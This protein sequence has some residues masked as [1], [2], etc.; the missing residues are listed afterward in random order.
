MPSAKLA[1]SL[2]VWLLALNFAS[3]RFFIT[4]IL[5]LEQKLRKLGSSEPAKA[6]A[7]K[8]WASH[9][10]MFKVCNENFASFCCVNALKHFC[11]NSW[12]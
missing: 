1:Q 9:L 7:R 4:R 12:S 6:L 8:K 10:E 3:Y 2:E 11:Y 5:L